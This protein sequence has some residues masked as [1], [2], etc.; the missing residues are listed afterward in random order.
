MS[1]KEELREELETVI[2]SYI[3]AKKNNI[4]TADWALIDLGLPKSATDEEVAAA[5]KGAQEKGCD[6]GLWKE[7]FEDFSPYGSYV[8]QMNAQGEKYVLPPNAEGL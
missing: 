1:K 2:K 5:F 7:C 4:P 3:H 6:L 8:S